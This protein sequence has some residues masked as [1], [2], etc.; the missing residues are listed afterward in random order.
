MATAKQETKVTPKAQKVAP[1]LPNRAQATQ[2]ATGILKGTGTVLDSAW[3]VLQDLGMVKGAEWQG[4]PEGFPSMLS[5]AKAITPQPMVHTGGKWTRMQ[6][7]SVQYV[8]PRDRGPATPAEVQH[9]K[10]VH[11]VSQALSDVSLSTDD[12][13]RGMCAPS[14]GR[15]AGKRPGSADAAT[16][17]ASKPQGVPTKDAA[18]ASKVLAKVLTGDK[19]ATPAA[20]TKVI[21]SLAEQITILAA[22][23]TKDDA[24]LTAC[25]AYVAAFSAPKVQAPKVTPATV[26]RTMPGSQVV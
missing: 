9:S 12:H 6:K 1:V 16:G 2:H 18:A 11:V 20:R 22:R 10:D 17:E 26:K 21:A 19:L 24:L 5:I 25:Q 7:A 8:A 4:F 13:V 14:K 15:P 3:L 23:G